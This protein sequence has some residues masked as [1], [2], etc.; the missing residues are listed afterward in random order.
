MKLLLTFFLCCTLCASQSGCK[1]KSSSDAE[2]LAKDIQST[3]KK[4]SPGTVATSADGFYMKAK[5]DGKEWE[6]SGML[7]DESAS[8]SYKTI[9]GEKG[10]TY[11]NFMIWRNGIKE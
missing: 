4:S 11:I 10:E 8:S 6:A 5:I 1:S 9:H 7:P 3:I 2:K